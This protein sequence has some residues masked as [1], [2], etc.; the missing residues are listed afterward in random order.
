MT[1]L[2][3]VE[4][5]L[6]KFRGRVLAASAAVLVCFLL[7]T[8]RL[9]WLQIVRHEDLDEQAEA[10]RTAIVPIVPNRG[11]I[12]D[13]NGIVLATNYSAYTLEITPSR[14]ARPVDVVVDELSRV[15]DIQ[16]RDRRRFKKLLEESKSIDSVPLRTKLS[17]EEVARFTVQRF[18]FPGAEIKARLF[19]N[20]PWGELAAHAIGYIGRINQPEKKQI[21]DWPE[22]EQSNYRGTE[23][24]GKLGIEQSFEKQLHGITGVEQVETSAGGRAVRKLASTPAT[25]GNTVKL[26]LDIKLQKLV[27]DLYGDRRGAMVAIDPKTGE[28]L[29]FVSKPTFDPNLFVDGIDQE[30]W[31][32][33]NES[34]DK[35]LLNRALRGTYPPGSTYKPF[36]ALAALE[37]GKRR[38]EQ[39]ISDPGYFWFGNHKFR[40]DK[41]GGH[42]SVDMY[43][44]IVQSCDTY[45]YMLAN[46]MGVDLI[47]E[48]LSH[49]GFGEITGIDIQGE[50][51]G[52]LPST[53]WKRKAYKRP[54]QQKW[55]AGETIS[56]G[57]GQGYNNFTVLQIATA[58]ATVA[59]P[60]GA[61]MKP[62]MVREVEDVVSK[63][64]QKIAP[65]QVGQL[66]AKPENL[67]IIRKA[68]VGV[69]IEGTSAAA[70]RGAGYSSG[71]KT[72]TAQVITIAQNAKYKASE[73][74]ERHRDHALFMAYAPAEDPKIAIAMVVENV[75]FGAANAAPI[76]RR[77]FDYYLLG[78]Y[79]SEEDIAL[80]RQGKATTPVGKPRPASEY[81]WPPTNMPTAPAATA[82]APGASVSPAAAV[83][84]AQT[85]AAAFSP[86]G[87]ATTGTPTAGTTFVPR[88]REQAPAAATAPQAR[89]SAARTTPP[90]R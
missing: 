21:E 76:V 84:Q 79:P 77:A 35:P 49:F 65:Q 10:N 87:T 14:L 75:G 24:I 71:G 11:L 51:R 61:R 25:P 28:I 72:G 8:S 47:H 2:R 68:L 39:A 37:T 86:L 64:V 22:D 7:L 66:T 60:Q 15:L 63:E 31:Q 13:R 3:N 56:L 48:Q 80:V 54:E 41:E 69:N 50:S 82:A 9:V 73:M 44:S 88:W 29:A 38:P 67:A 32:A 17:D 26:S 57:I 85:V 40:D 45:Y 55:Y 33:L 36:M 52:L 53:E 4:A 58:T 43:K 18:R 81:A 83:A 27:E 34:I 70:F 90:A 42:G 5:D 46:D 1:E 12:L 23:Y 89:S 19:R 78:Q 30:N 59:N 20:Y 74:E 6:S 16:Q 62:H